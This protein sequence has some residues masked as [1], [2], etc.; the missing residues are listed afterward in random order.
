MNLISYLDAAKAKFG[1]WMAMVPPLEGRPA[2]WLTEV[3]AFEVPVPDAAML[4]GFLFLLLLIHR[5]NRS[6]LGDVQGMVEQAY[7]GELL[8]ANRRVY[9][10]RN[11]LR[12][13]EL[14]IERE[15]QRKRRLQYQNQSARRSP[16]VTHL[17]EIKDRA[18]TRPRMG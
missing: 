16:R 2:E 8:T 11:E 13:A 10:A 17:R 15:R 3:R 4:A 18:V 14:E 7:R 1:E 12:K 9:Q 6:A 5:S